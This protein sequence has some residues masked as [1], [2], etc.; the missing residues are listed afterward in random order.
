MAIEISVCAEEDLGTL[1]GIAIET[2]EDSFGPQNE[3]ETMANYLREAMGEARLLG[4]LRRPGSFFYFIHE[5]GR[6]AGYLKLNSAWA[7]RSR[8]TT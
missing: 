5:E 7:R 1:R 8:P 3:A 6:L 4:E 2:Y